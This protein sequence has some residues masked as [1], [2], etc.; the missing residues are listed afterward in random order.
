[1]CQ[2]SSGVEYTAA[3]PRGK[4][5]FQMFKGLG[6]PLSSSPATPT[7]VS[8]YVLGSGSE[9]QAAPARCY[10]GLLP[11]EKMFPSSTL[12]IRT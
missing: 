11:R 9:A 7:L 6:G 1:M 4:A 8:M 3:C 12:W 5:S 10:P 2:V